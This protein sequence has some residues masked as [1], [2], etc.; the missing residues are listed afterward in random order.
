[1]AFTVVLKALLSLIAGLVFWFLAFLVFMVYS[2]MPISKVP[3][4][5]YFTVIAPVLYLVFSNLLLRRLFRE[6]G[7]K[8]L[9][10]NLAVTLAMTGISLVVVDL[11]ARVAR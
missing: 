11:A 6:S 8:N 4:S 5:V 7:R 2:F 10:V 9:A 1:M 3:N